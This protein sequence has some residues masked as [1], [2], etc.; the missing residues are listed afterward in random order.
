MQAAI[1]ID[2]GG[3]KI[4]GGL[5]D[6]AVGALIDQAELPTPRGLGADAILAAANDIAGRMHRSAL[7]KGIATVG[8]GLGL[9]ELVDLNGAPASGWIADWS[10]SDIA[11]ALSSY[12]PIAVDSDVRVAA[13]AEL[14]FGHGKT[15]PSF[16]FVS[17]GT[18]LSFAGCS[19]GRIQ[20]GANGFAIHFASSE[21]VTFDE[22]SGKRTDFLLESF[23]SGLGMARVYKARTGRSATARDIVE[24]RAGAQ[25]A[26]L[27]DEATTALA[28][29]LGQMINMIDPHGVVV[30]GGLGTAQPYFDRLRSEVPSYIWA[31]QCREL[32]VLASALG[33]AAGVIGAAALHARAK[34]E[35]D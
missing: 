9:P 4:A 11:G 20:R 17:V 31:E 7:A 14:H 12:G 5:V 10:R 18:G 23:A 34:L 24:G 26:Q 35:R 6:L 2:I 29:Y 25:G 28:S 3:T 8:L 19:D 1:G 30:G 13:L 15:L 32:P 21:L 33:S 16:V 22:A 27:L